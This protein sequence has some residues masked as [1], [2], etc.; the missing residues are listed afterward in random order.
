M[1]ASGGT[2]VLVMGGID[3][4]AGIEFEGAWPSWRS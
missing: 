3:Q 2:T 4:A 1:V